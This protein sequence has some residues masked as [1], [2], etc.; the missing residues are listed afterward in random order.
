MSNLDPQVPPPPQRVPL[1]TQAGI[2]RDGTPLDSMNW[3]DG[4]WVR[5][6][7]GRPKKMGGYRFMT[8]YTA[9]PI[10]MCLVDARA[11][12]YTLHTFSPWGVEALQFDPITGA[13]GGIGE[14]TP[15]GFVPNQA[16]TWQATVM[17]NNG[18]SPAYLCC[19]GTPDEPDIS[20]DTAGGVYYG[21]ITNLIAA[22]API[23]SATVPIT[24]SGG[25]VAIGPFLFVYGSNGLIWNS[26]PNNISDATGWVPGSTG[27]NVFANTANPIDK[28]IVKGLPLRGGALSPAG[29]FWGLN[30]LVR[31]SFNPG[32]GSFN[33][34][35]YDL[36][37]TISVLGKNAII[38]YDG[39][40]YW[41]GVDRFF[42][43]NGVVQE[44]PNQ[45]N[46]NWFFDNLNHSLSNLVWA[47][48]VPRYGE[49]WWFY[50]RTGFFN[51]LNPECTHV[52]IF[53]VRE[54]TWYDVQLVRSS[55]MEA[56]IFP[57][58][59]MTGGDDDITNGYYLPY[60]TGTGTFV[61]NETVTG[62]TSGAVATI[63]RVVTG[64][65]TVQA[66]SK[67]FVSGETI[68]GSVSGATGT[69]TAASQQQDIDTVWIHEYGVDKILDT[70]GPTAIPAYVTTQPIS[71]P[72]GGPLAA[73]GSVQW[74][75]SP[76]SEYMTRCTRFEPDFTALGGGNRVT[77]AMSITVSGYAYANS[78]DP[79]NGGP[80][81]SS[82][83]AFDNTTQFIEMREQKRELLLTFTSNTLGGFFEF[84][85]SI[86]TIEQG[87]GRP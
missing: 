20:I 22:L 15:T 12:A 34:W 51:P 26:N 18:G 28:K 72:T 25:T 45:M 87:D 57:N 79:S 39:I 36:L 42:V 5:F 86:L 32:G 61:M 6:Q 30:Q 27:N 44:L 84:G 63:Y 74:Q 14:R 53:N 2:K 50:P 33:Y 76:G 3:T 11:G 4:Q 55:G 56:D 13:G 64:S 48:K 10:R 85:R 8:R 60:T 19:A 78:V 9:G 68:T 41:P 24:V 83:Y 29:L 59:I 21:D 54:N 17:V 69:T 1:L 35:K 81:V 75:G 7:R 46:L 66:P 70:T 23:T 37:G 67:A 73:A 31:A 47:L 16:L 80:Q 62:G 71:Y 40:Y 43:Y 38:E 52:V 58:P 65:L 82:P 77:G 49:I